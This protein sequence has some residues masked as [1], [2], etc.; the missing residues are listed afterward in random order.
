MMRKSLWI[1]IVLSCNVLTALAQKY[2]VSGIVCDQDTREPISGVTVVIKS[3]R[4][5]SIVQYGMTADDGKFSLQVSGANLRDYNLQVSCLGYEQRVLG[6][7]GKQS[8]TVLLKEKAIELQELSVRPDKII[9]NKDTTSYLVA[10]FATPKDRTIGDVLANMPGINVAEDGK[11][12]YNGSPIN[13]FYVEGVDLLNGKYNLATHNISYGNI[14]RVDV[15]ENHQAVKALQ[16]TGLETGTAINLKLKDSAK[17]C[18]NGKV[19]G[20]GGIAPDGGLWD[21]E[22]FASRFAAKSQSLSTLKSNNT[23]TN[24]SDENKTLTMDDLLDSYPGS[25]ISGNIQ[26][27][28]SLS[29]DID[30]SRTRF[31]KSYAFSNS[32]MWKLSETAQIKTQI[33][34]AD[35]RDDFNQGVESRYY[36]TDSVLTKGTSEEGF[37]RSKMLQA[38]VEAVVNEDKYYLSDELKCSSNWTDFTSDITGDYNYLSL[39]HTRTHNVENKL[40]YIRKSGHNIF[41]VMSLNKYTYLPEKLNV[42]GASDTKR[43]SI[44]KHNFFSNTDVQFVHNVRRWAL[45]T[46]LDVFG[47]IYDFK[48][49]Y[50]GGQEHYNNDV[51]VNYIGWKLTPDVAYEKSAVRFDASVPVSVYCFHGES[52]AKRLYVR[53]EAYL[54]WK[55]MPQW[56]LFVNAAAGSSYTD[57]SL[58]YT[59]PVL[60]DYKSFYTGFIHYDGKEEAL[61]GGRISYAVPSEMLFANLSV[62]YSVENR[63]QC[64]SKQVSNDHIYYA[65]MPGNDEYK[66][67]FSEGSLSK[68]LDCINGTVELRGSYQN[69]NMPI[70]QNG[71]TSVFDFGNAYVSLGVKSNATDWMNVDYKVGYRYNYL[72]FD[73]FKSATRYIQQRCQLTF[74][75]TED[76]NITLNG[77]HYLIM[78]GSGQHQNTVL[79]DMEVTYKYKQFDFLAKIK[80]IFNQRIYSYTT[81]G[82]LSSTGTQY[83]IRGMNILLGMSWYF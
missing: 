17:S 79:A 33:D 69:H 65:Y 13:K 56:T 48:S 25:D 75:P 83:D 76:M 26:S 9:Q 64:I 49:A 22:L 80:N 36:L 8:L 5:S 41:K 28:P 47:N 32:N 77:E 53:P 20:M 23:G 59:A 43:Q 16:G 66:L 14:A 15:I 52:S 12:S 68:G 10:G 37:V 62:S 24:L 73:A 2:N 35:D 7:S 38:S 55:V 51:S 60:V 27:K 11:I 78:F 6:L 61:V 72:R 18:W 63:K 71:D 57:N 30:E 46:T 19:M 67:L 39:A 42:E 1:G 58:Y 40:K 31:N 21:G 70:E 34:Y 74:Y 3:K 82:D 29:T 45:G 81:Y 44:H 50:G 4:D 54:K